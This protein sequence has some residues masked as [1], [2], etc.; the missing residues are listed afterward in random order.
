MLNRANRIGCLPGVT[1]ALVNSSY[2]KRAQ[3]LN[4]N[5]KHHIGF[6]Q[7]HRACPYLNG[8]FF[9]KSMWSSRSPQKRPRAFNHDYCMRMAVLNFFAQVG[10]FRSSDGTRN[11]CSLKPIF[12]L[13]VKK[14][15]LSEFD[16]SEHSVVRLAK[17]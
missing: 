10:S 5:L 8:V 6:V 7:R 15:G 1:S 13:H 12:H 3:R 11:N 16:I 17:E 2:T 4:S 14:I 9:L